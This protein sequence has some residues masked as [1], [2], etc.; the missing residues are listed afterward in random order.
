MKLNIELID[1]LEHNCLKG[2]IASIAEWKKKDYT[3]VYAESW[4]FVMNYEI[5][6]IN[7]QSFVHLGIPDTLKYDLLKS[8]TGI[9]LN[10][11]FNK[12]K[13]EFIT[14]VKSELAQQRPIIIMLDYF[15]CPWNKDVSNITR[16]PHHASVVV[17]FDELG[18][19]CLDYSPRCDK[20][21]LPYENI[22]YIDEYITINIDKPTYDYNYGDIIKRSINVLESHDIFK[23]MRRFGN[24]I[25]ESFDPVK[26]LEDVENNAWMPNIWQ[27]TL[28]AEGRCLYSKTLRTISGKNKI[29]SLLS[30][31]ERLDSTKPMWTIVISLLT[32]IYLN[33]DLSLR[34]KLA[35]KIYEIADFEE[36]I[37]CSL[38]SIIKGSL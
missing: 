36:D 12:S 26:Y 30:I 21:T 1:N 34:K 29:G 8:S 31:A 18:F 5:K 33:K 14:T 2:L 24:F 28:I 22:V 13:E 38:T 6:G 11:I 9:S 32:K 16:N 27:L 7:P 20:C 23:A 19:N 15:W 17:G 37:Y 3:L 10:Q 35:K 25:E 4:D